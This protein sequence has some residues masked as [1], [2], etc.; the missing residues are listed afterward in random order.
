MTPNKDDLAGLEKKRIYEKVDSII[1]KVGASSY[2]GDN[3]MAA[4]VMDGINIRH[5]LKDK[6]LDTTNIIRTVKRAQ[7]KISDNLHHDLKNIS[8]IIYSNI[9]ELREDGRSVSRYGSWI[10]GIY[11]DGIIRI[12]N[13]RE[14]EDTAALYITLTHEIVHLAVDEIGKKHCPYWLD[15]GLAVHFSQNLN[16]AYLNILNNALKDD[17]ILPLSNLARPLP[18]YTDE[19]VL[20][21]AYAQSA[22]MVSFLID[23]CGM[24]KISK[25]IH[26]CAR[27]DINTALCDDLG[28]NYYLLE[29]QWKRWMRNIAQNKLPI[30]LKGGVDD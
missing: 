10:A 16:D 1:R 14:E 8:I 2:I 11:D 23:T 15:E 5:H 18:A 24:G 29:I 12:I 19:S 13:F 3:D 28:M 6:S 9:G 27:M 4:L 22:S 21:L 25:L 17:A 20:R 26:Q 7:K 30:R